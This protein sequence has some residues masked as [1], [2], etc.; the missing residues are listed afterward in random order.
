MV[1]IVV[2]CVDNND[3]NISCFVKFNLEWI[4]NEHYPNFIIFCWNYCSCQIGFKS[5]GTTI[6][7]VSI[8][9]QGICPYILIYTYSGSGEIIC[10]SAQLL[11]IHVK[12]STLK[13]FLT[14]AQ[15]LADR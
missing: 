4:S 8:T 14:F 2:T 9:D 10:F 15:S 13:N 6:T 1:H 5:N 12:L 11:N 7:T 3:N